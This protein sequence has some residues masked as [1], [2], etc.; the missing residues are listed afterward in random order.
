MRAPPESNNPAVEAIP[1]L[2]VALGFAALISI[3]L[4]FLAAYGP[5]FLPDSGGYV[6]IGNFILAGRLNDPALAG[7]IFPPTLFRIIG[8]PAII[9]LMK[10]VS[11]EFWPWLVVALQ[12]AFSFAATAA[13]Y[14]LAR[15]FGLGFWLSFASA[16]LQATSLPLVLDQ[17][18]ITDSLYA[19]LITLAICTL[20]IAIVRGRLRLAAGIGVGLLLAAAF[21]LREATI[22]MLLGFVP[23]AGAAAFRNGLPA[24]RKIVALIGILLPLILIHQLYL[25]WNRSRIGARIATSAAQTALVL[26]L[27]DAARHEPRIFSGDT[28]LD[29]VARQVVRNHDFFEVR[30]INKRL[31]EERGR[32]AAQMAGDAHDAYFRAWREYPR[33]MLSLPLSHMNE[34]IVYLMARPVTSLRDLI[35][36]NTGGDNGF[37]REQALRDGRWWMLPFII[38]YRFGQAASIVLFAAFLALTPWRF[39]AAGWRSPPAVAAAGI[40]FAYLTFFGIYAMVHLEPRYIMGVVSPAIVVAVANLFWLFEWL[41]ARIPA[42]RKLKA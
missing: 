31:F 27:V 16:T 41:R 11:G 10:A 29:Q 14:R 2:P 4:G 39:L 42:A 25:E 13:T 9:A 7:G 23:L 30:E 15:A 36:W 20:A 33:A 21:L 5:T 40:W 8:Y 28:A 32:S 18:I 34:R 17:A 22:F 19:S 35:V 3:K 6:D 1:V 24:S 37:A 12:F 38:V 26:A